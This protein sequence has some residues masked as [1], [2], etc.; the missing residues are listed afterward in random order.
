[1]GHALPLVSA[2]L[3]V[4]ATM[5]FVASSQSLP[6]TPTPPHPRTTNATRNGHRNY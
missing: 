6:P 1:M 2:A 4:I 5:P 3:A